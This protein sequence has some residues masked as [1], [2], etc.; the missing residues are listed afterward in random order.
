VQ[1]R[2]FVRYLSIC[3]RLYSSSSMV[4]EKYWRSMNREF[5]VFY[6]Q[7]LLKVSV[8]VI[9]KK[10]FLKRDLAVFLYKG[11]TGVLLSSKQNKRVLLLT[12]IKYLKHFPSHKQNAVVRFWWQKYRSLLFPLTLWFTLESHVVRSQIEFMRYLWLCRRMWNLLP[13]QIISPVLIS[14]PYNIEWHV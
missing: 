4:T 13:K 14:D 3:V 7:D 2:I 6:F 11:G 5:C 8:A 9:Q 1:S 10:M 12:I